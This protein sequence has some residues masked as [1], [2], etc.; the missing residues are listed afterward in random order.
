MQTKELGRIEWHKICGM[1]GGKAMLISDKETEL[2]SEMQY[3]YSLGEPSN[4]PRIEAIAKEIRKC[5]RIQKQI[6]RGKIDL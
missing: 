2:L 3:L 1:N 6:M 4:K 5:Q